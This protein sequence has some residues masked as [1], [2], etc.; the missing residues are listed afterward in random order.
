ME[1]FLFDEFQNVSAK[2]WKQKI[3][4]DL[5]GADYNKTLLTNTREGIT[6]KPFYHHDTY[7]QLSVPINKDDFVIC[8]SIYVNEE[9]TANLLAKDALIRGANAIKFIVYKDFNFKILLQKLFAA[10]NEKVKI[11]F[12]FHFID[13][14]FI[15]QLLDFVQEKNIY[16]NLDIIGN[17]AKNGNWFSDHKKDYNTLTTFFKSTNSNLGILAVNASLYQNSGANIVQQIAYTLCHANEYLNFVFGLYKKNEIQ[18]KQFET[19]AK[20]MQFNFSIGGNYFFEIAKIRAFRVLWKL[21]INEYNLDFSANIFAEPSSRNKSIYDYNVN[22]L[23]TTTECMSAILGGVNTISNLAYDNIFHKKNE[24]GERIARNQLIILKEESKLKNSD[25]VKGTYYIEELTTEI[26]EKSLTIFKEIEKSGGFLKQ[27]F[28]GTIQRKIHENAQKEQEEFDKGTEVL[29][30]ANKYPNK[31]DNIKD[32]LELYPFLRTNKR[33][34]LIKPI[35]A[36]RLAE[37][38]EKIRMKAE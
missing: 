12:E 36:I 1:N 15:L 24:F 13:E 2:Q 33:E 22:M 9:K 37:K 20:H 35:I 29:I 10:P 21:L 38:M 3:Q 30:G 26:A 27:L 23:R 14:S 25:F 16:L 17:L 11:Y 28:E 32:T 34:T 4:F 5:K 7:K 19:L 8:Q 18:I 31:E 6:I